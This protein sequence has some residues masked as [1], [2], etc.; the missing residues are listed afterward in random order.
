MS[1]SPT[2]THPTSQTRLPFSWRFLLPQYWGI[3][4][5]MACVLPGVWLPLRVQFWLGRTLGVLLYQTIARRRC[6]TLI[7]MALIF[8]EKS[9]AEHAQLAK[10]VFIQ[11]GVGVFESLCAWFRP[12]VFDGCWDVTGADAV[13]KAQHNGHAVI[14]LG[15]HYTL[16]DLGGLLMSHVLPIDVIYRPQNN[17]L[18]D[19]FIFN[20]R[21]HIYRRQISH[22][23]MRALAQ[24]LKDGR[25]VWYSPDQDFGLKQ[26]VMAP[27][28]GVPAATIT[29]QRRLARLGNK[30]K[31]PVFFMFHA[32]RT[33]APNVPRPHYQLTL[34]PPLSDYP[35]QNET[36]DAARINALLEQLML[37]DPTQYMWFHRRFKTQPDGTKYYA[38]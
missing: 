18:L 36:A 31:P 26:G 37:V 25:A 24:S 10:R 22:R 38:K 27:F 2:S 28:F 4:L 19:W 8:P 11:A 7:N 32:Y 34:S 15:A 14:L 21:T 6:D 29:A 20:A 3:W 17:A 16:L 35:S 5:L 9:A 23:D 33:T 1:F 12:H 13:L 30:Q